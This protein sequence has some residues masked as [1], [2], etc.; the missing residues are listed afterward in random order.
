MGG[1]HVDTIFGKSCHNEYLDS[2]V[3]GYG[4]QHQKT[5]SYLVKVASRTKKGPKLLSD[6]LFLGP[7]IAITELSSV[8][9]VDI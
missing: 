7:K 1:K 3:L 9:L 4:E 6:D 5:S 8:T 2:I